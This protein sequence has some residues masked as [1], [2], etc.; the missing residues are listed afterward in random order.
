VPFQGVDSFRWQIRRLTGP[1]A[2]VRCQI[3]PNYYTAHECTGN[4]EGFMGCELLKIIT[5]VCMAIQNYPTPYMSISHD[6]GFAI[7]NGL[8]K[9][10]LRSFE[11]I[12]L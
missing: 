1:Y 12:G 11:A 4:G 10:D 2:L 8:L 6:Q 9:C 3:M 5:E 7:N